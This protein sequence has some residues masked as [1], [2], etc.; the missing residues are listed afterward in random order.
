MVRAISA[1]NDRRG[2]KMRKSFK[3]KRAVDSSL[4]REGDLID[5]LK[6]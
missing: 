5:R 4:D 3:L 1:R 6:T 2:T